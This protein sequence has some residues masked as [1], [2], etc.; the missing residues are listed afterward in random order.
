[1][2]EFGFEFEV[3]LELKFE[4]ELELELSL[5][6][7]LPNFCPLASPYNGAGH[8]FTV[9]KKT[10]RQRVLSC[11]LASWQGKLFVQVGKI[12]FLT[13]CAMLFVNPHSIAEATCSIKE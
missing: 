1:M 10:K 7:N 9:K 13:C 3:E 6:S 8:I 11:L 2:F 5:C 12:N 4:L